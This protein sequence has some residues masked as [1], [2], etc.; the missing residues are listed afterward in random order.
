[1]SSTTSKRIRTLS[2][3]VF[4][5][6]VVTAAFALTL[7][8][9][10]KPRSVLAYTI[11]SKR[12][13]TPADGGAPRHEVTMARYQKSDGTWKELITYFD[14]N[15]AFYKKTTAFGQPGRGVFQVD[16]EKKEMSFISP[17]ESAIADL[18]LFDLRNDPR[19]VKEASVLGYQTFVLREIED[20]SGDYTENYLAPAFHNLS[21]KSISFSERRMSVLE[22]V[23]IKIGEPNEGE[24]TSL[25]NWEIKYDLFQEKIQ[26]L[27]DRG[28]N[29]VADQMR[30][31]LQRGLQQKPDRR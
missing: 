3:A 13:F 29:E 14:P 15:G 11:I 24:F 31:E 7:N 19:L 22:P 1:M 21:L 8:Q 16:E 18:P 28:N 4:L 23:E 17:M 26:V 30:Q 20:S 6:G 25:P 27:E 5:L 9:V 12:T 2:V 10:R